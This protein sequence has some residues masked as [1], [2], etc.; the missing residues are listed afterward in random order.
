[1]IRLACSASVGCAEVLVR[2]CRRYQPRETGERFRGRRPGAENLPDGRT[3]CSFALRACRNAEPLGKLV[4]ASVPPGLVPSVA[5]IQTRQRY[6]KPRV[7]SAF[8]A[9]HSPR[10]RCWAVD[11]GG[12]VPSGNASLAS[13]GIAGRSRLDK[14]RQGEERGER[15]RE[16]DSPRGRGAVRSRSARPSRLACCQAVIPG[17]RSV[18]LASPAN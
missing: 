3:S 4:F 14:G 7:A 18:S 16:R 1:L 6:D 11:L 2:R 5:D 12:W 17:G 10:C 13:F 8:D 9:Q 15:E